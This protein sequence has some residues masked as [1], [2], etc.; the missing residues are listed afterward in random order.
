MTMPMDRADPQSRTTG[1]NSAGII[2]WFINN[3]VAANLLMLFLIAG[4]V[5]AIFSIRT[6]LFPTVDPRTITVTVAYP[7]ATPHEVEEGITRRV[8]EAVMG[9]D[10]VR[11]ISSIAQ[12][13]VGVVIVEVEEFADI[14]EALNDVEMAVAQLIDFPP[15][16]AEAPIIVKDR[17]QPAVITLVLHGDVPELTLKRWAERLRDEMLMTPGIALIELR[18]AREYQ[19]SIEMTEETLRQYHLSIEEVGALVGAFSVNL[20]AGEVRSRSGD[21]VLRVQEKGYTGTDFESILVRS[22]PDGTLLR[23]KDIAT[24]VDGFDDSHLMTRYNGRPAVFLQIT[25][26]EAQDTLQVERAV[27][28]Y[29]EGLRLPAA[30]ELA[31]MENRTEMLRQR[32]NLLARN[33]ILGFALVFLAL[34][35][36][37]DLKLALWT[38]MGIAISFLGGLLIVFLFGLSFNMVTLFALIVVLGIVVDD[39]IVTGESIFSEQESGAVGSQAALRGVRAI[40][41]PV[42][43]GVFTSVGAFAP[44]AFSTGV[45]GQIMRP[46]PIFVISILLISLVEAFFI[47]PAHLSSSARWSR[48]IVAT[49]SRRFNQGLNRFVDRWVLTGLRAAILW[50]YAFLAAAVALL[51]IIAGLFRGGFVRFIFF[52]QIEGDQVS[53][54]LVMPVGT[55]FETTRRHALEMVRAANQVDEELFEETGRRLFESTS[56]IV[57]STLQQG[58]GPATGTDRGQA[59][60][61]LAEILIQLIP[62]QERAV[63]AEEIG[64]RFQRAIGRIPN[65]DELTVE[66]GLV[67]TD[68]DINIQLAHEDVAVLYQ[69]AALLKG[70]METMEG[71]TQITDTLKAG[72]LE[73]LFK[74]T[75]AGLAAGLRPADVGRQLRSAF[76]GHEV[77]RIQRGRSELKVMVRYPAERREH[78]QDIENF[79]L[80]LP[81]GDKAPLASMTHIEQQRTF[82]QIRRVDG[83][84]VVNVTADVDT[85]ITTPGEALDIIMSRVVPPILDTYPGMTATVEGFSRE[86]Q[87]DMADLGRNMLIALLIIFVMLGAQLRSYMQP[88]VIMAII[89]FGFVGAFLGHL[90]LGYDLSFISLFGLVALTGVVINDS[91]VLIDYYNRQRRQGGGS[92]AAEKNARDNTVDALE[93]AVRRR[94]RP[95]LLTTMTTSLALLPM[96]LETSLQARFLIPMAISLAFGL[97]FASM[98]MLFLLPAMIMMVDDVRRRI[99]GS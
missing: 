56:V 18:G 43:V 60:G 12:E 93:Q 96:L 28:D 81:G 94:F 16:D 58:A 41:A 61:N 86:R 17:P 44:L 83:R 85:H 15:V 88:M 10:G 20:P 51:I 45:L 9:T 23:L 64:N 79:R 42:S 48:G 99:G 78:I 13:N 75:D 31:I 91:V 50:R 35:L 1:E 80:T 26:S 47:L 76:Y 34:V 33:A 2:A 69:A 72:K 59:I 4:G 87:E 68:A 19:I 49:I 5:I 57:G 14:D 82:S 27:L 29:I 37:L 77:Q 67:G 63:S 24:I 74:L 22:R 6:E 7:G 98:V 70:R 39:A 52:P 38:S 8:E 62:G 54:R 97:L 55:P 40:I 92:Q 36:F 71:V 66:S 3:H 89:P 30:I 84:R 32:I 11:Q 65:A 90:I 21:I 95:I 46:I 73:Y 53:A 25:R